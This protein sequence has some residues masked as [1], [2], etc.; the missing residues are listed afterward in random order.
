VLG[1]EGEV[2][3]LEQGPHR[4]IGG[5]PSRQTK[6]ERRDAEAGFARGDRI[7]RWHKL[8]LDL[9]FALVHGGTAQQADAV[10]EVRRV[11]ACGGVGARLFTR[12]TH[13]A[14]HRLE[15]TSWSA[16]IF[17]PT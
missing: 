8:V 12:E 2:H 11:T 9:L 13:A 3:H 10:K 6:S 17:E 14:T 16:R 7:L 1:H 4:A 15:N 5:I